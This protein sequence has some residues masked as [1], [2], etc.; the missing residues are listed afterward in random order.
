MSDN[1]RRKLIPQDE[2]GD[3]IISGEQLNYWDAWVVS[4]YI[5][6]AGSFRVLL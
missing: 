6:T 3:L 4:W 5:Y 1:S 2:T